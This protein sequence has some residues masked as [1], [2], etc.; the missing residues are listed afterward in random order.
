MTTKD[1]RTTKRRW[2]KVYPAEWINGSIRYQMTSAQRGVWIDILSF[3]SLCSNTGVIC[4][5][6]GRALPLTFLANRL[7]I[8]A[9]LLNATLAICEADGRLSQ[10]ATGIHVT[11]WDR[12]QSE[13]DRQKPGRQAKQKPAPEPEPDEVPF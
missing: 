5:R 3:A 7:N 6:D 4:D 2:Y 8:S 9:K 12:Y 10:D 1:L 11:N 13:Y